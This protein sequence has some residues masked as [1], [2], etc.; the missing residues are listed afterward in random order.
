MSVRSSSRSIAVIALLVS[1]AAACSTASNK[2]STTSPTTSGAGS[3]STNGKLTASATGVTP[4]TIKIGFSYPDLA[5]LAKTG[6][7]KIDNG[8]Y[9]PMMQALVNDV[10]KHGGVDGRKLALSLASFDVLGATA[11]T[12]ACTKL[13]EDDKVFVVL[14]GFLADNNLCITQQHAT[15]LFSFYGSGFNKVNLAKAQAPWFTQNASDERA[16]QALVKLLDQ[17]GRLN[18]K[19]AI[20]GQTPSSKSLVDLAATALEAT[21]HKAADTAV[22]DVDATDQ[23]AYTAQDKVLAQRFKDKGIDTLILVGGTPT[24]SD[25]DAVGWHPSIYSPQA[26]LITPGAYTSP[27][28]K[29]PFIA[30]VDAGADPNAGYNTPAMKHCRAVWK[31]ATGK[32]ILTAAQETAQ[33]KST[34]NSA[35]TTACTALQVFDAAA[36]AAGPNLTAQTW[37]KGVESLGTIAMPAMPVGSFGPN[38]PDAQDKFQLERHDPTWTPTSTKPEFIPVG[39]PI[40]LSN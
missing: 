13:T 16:L 31:Q 2:A 28:Q 20:E 30:G 21:G 39:A 10:N 32:D 8:P 11:Q 37:A 22:I 9:G 25:Y 14:G 15:P 26:G 34:G 19:I 35:M 24:A 40:T 1:F 12:A 23:Q 38:K 6:L 33:G 5:A 17:Q 7:I 27:Y 4:T 18:G 29:F 3:G 36:D